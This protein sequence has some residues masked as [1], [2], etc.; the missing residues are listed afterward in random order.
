MKRSK[1]FRGTRPELGAEVG[2][3]GEG[4]SR[5]NK[6]ADPNSSLLLIMAEERIGGVSSI[7]KPEKGESSVPDDSGR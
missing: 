6:L 4:F 7:V 3:N 2:A 5:L 1:R